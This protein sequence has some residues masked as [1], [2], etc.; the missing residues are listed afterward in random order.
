M[1]FCTKLTERERREGRLPSNLEYSLPTE[2]EWEYACRAGTTGPFH[3]GSSLDS[4]MANINGAYPYGDGRKGVSREKTIEVGSFKSN[5]WD[6]YDMHGNVWEWCLDWL[7]DYL[8]GTV[9]DPIGSSLSLGS[10]RVVRGGDL[11]SVA[12]E[13]R[14]PSRNR[15]RPYERVYA[16]GFRL[17]LRKIY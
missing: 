13:C 12:M 4:S 8:S 11:D 1:E 15:G 6:L 10:D 7:G 2:A 9:T 3:Y 14:S 5:A 17:C 16:V